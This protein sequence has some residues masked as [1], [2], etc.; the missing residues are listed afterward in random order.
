MKK[1]M[2]IAVLTLAALATTTQVAH[3]TL[4]FCPPLCSR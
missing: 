2:L 3:A 4:P 1:I